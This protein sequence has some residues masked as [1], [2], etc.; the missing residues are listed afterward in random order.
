LAH[1]A[2]DLRP[3]G[4]IKSLLQTCYRN[5]QSDGYLPRPEVTQGDSVQFATA[6]RHKDCHLLIC[7]ACRNSR[8]IPVYLVRSQDAL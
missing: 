5:E 3:F 6:R 1:S 2:N 7:L 4:Q 8:I